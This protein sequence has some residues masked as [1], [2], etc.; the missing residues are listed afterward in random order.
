MLGVI[1][2][3]LKVQATI[4]DLETDTASDYS[5]MVSNIPYSATENEIS[6]FFEKT[7]RVKVVKITLSYNVEKL[8]SLL[9][10]KEAVEDKLTFLRRKEE[11]NSQDSD[12]KKNEEQKLKILEEQIASIRQSFET[13]HETHFTGKAFISFEYMKQVDDV[14]DQTEMSTIKWVFNKFKYELE[15]KGN[16]ALFRQ[17]FES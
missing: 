7:F 4:V 1:R 10:Q 15:F 11:L 14:L 9:N 6:A 8:V 5:I 13:H 16:S 17:V 12:R 3:R 2:H